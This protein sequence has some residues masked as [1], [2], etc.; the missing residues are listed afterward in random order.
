[1]RLKRPAWLVRGLV[2]LLVAADALAQGN[3]Q[4]LNFESASIPSGTQPPME[5]PIGSALPGWSASISWSNNGTYNGTFPQ[6]QVLYDITTVG[7]PGIG[8]MSTD[9][10]YAH[11]LPLQGSYSLWLA[12]GVSGIGGR[13]SSTINQTGLVPRGTLSVLMDVR[14]DYGFTV[15]LGGQD[16]HM[17]PL[18][19]YPSYTLDG[20]D[21]S[22][23]A[24]QTA[25]LSITAP[26]SPVSNPSDVLLDDITFSPNP[27]PEPSVFGLFA[28][29]ALL[30]GWRGPLRKMV[31][32]GCPAPVGVGGTNRAC[33][34]PHGS[35]MAKALAASMSQSG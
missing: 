26:Y 34:F 31:G 16:I 35:K 19:T 23:F 15:S 5:V 14:T 4:N 13:G 11:W 12:G 30:L 21:V 25:K 7:S 22:A 8:I 27:I 1:M 33:G 20:G 10:G 28:S 3:F 18:Q 29:G 24:G 6:S 9:V 2:L 17:V 32:G